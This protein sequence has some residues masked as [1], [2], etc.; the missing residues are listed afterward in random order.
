MNKKNI[1]EQ[2][3]YLEEEI[4]SVYGVQEFCH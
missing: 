2:V 4:F 1:E 3:R